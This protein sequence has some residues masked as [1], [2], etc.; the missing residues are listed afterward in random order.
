MAEPYD[1]NLGSKIDTFLVGK[2]SPMAGNGSVFFSNGVA[3]NVDPR[4]VVAIAGAETS[5]GTNWGL[6]KPAS[7]N[8]WSWFYD[9]S[10]ANR[11]TNST[12][13]SYAD[14]IGVVTSGIRRL[15]LNKGFTT[16]PLIAKLYCGSGCGSWIPSVTGSYTTLGG[17]VSDLTF[18]TTLIDFEQFTGPCCFTGVQPPLTVGI[19][20]VSGGQILSGTSNLPADQSV[21]YGTAYFCPGCSP[22]ITITFSQK[23]SNVSLFLYNGLTDTVTYTVADD[24]GGSQTVTLSSNLQS[25]TATVSLPDVGISQVTISGALAGE[26]D[27]FVDNVRFAPE[28][29]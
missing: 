27:F 12:F 7:F 29:S 24:K 26:W 22:T 25:G 13:S 23:V 8:A 21:L 3:D 10:G 20:T 4:L 9:A 6:C 17:D 11:C 2:G 28:G 5:F 16:I 19:A 18:A 1:P 14:G 15:Y